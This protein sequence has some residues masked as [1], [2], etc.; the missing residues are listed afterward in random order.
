MLIMKLKRILKYINI[1]SIGINYSLISTVRSL[2]V[3]G[4]SVACMI[5]IGPS[6]L[7]L[8]ST[9]SIYLSYTPLIFLGVQSSLNRE[10]PILLGQKNNDKALKLVSNARSVSIFISITIILF[11]LLIVLIAIK[12]NSNINNILSLVAVIII[13][14]SESYRVHLIATYRTTNS[15]IKLTKIYIIEILFTILFLFIIYKYKYVGFLVYSVFTIMLNVFLLSYWSPYRNIKLSFERE[16][17]QFL[18]KSGFLLMIFAQLKQAI[19][20]FAKWVIIIYGDNIQL[21]LFT[22]AFAIGALMFMIPDQIANFISPKIGFNYGEHQNASNF[23]PHIQKAIILLPLISLPISFLI[24]IFSPFILN[25]F[26]PKYH[27]SLWAIRF[28]SIGF[29]FSS[30]FLTQTVLYTIK[31]HKHIFLF[32]ML[33]GLGYFLIPILIMKISNYNLIESVAIGISITSILLYFINFFMIKFLLFS[34]KYNL[35]HNLTI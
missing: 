27:E 35:N 7:G 12:N 11:G 5:W 26:M 23:W 6:D 33:E 9:V 10:L 4:I 24:W 22:P 17:F 8:W 25:S 31:A 3:V 30:S 1:Y 16:H 14:T 20:T 18:L 21:G 19:P 32:L 2:I 15:F 13:A 34:R 28:M 29:V